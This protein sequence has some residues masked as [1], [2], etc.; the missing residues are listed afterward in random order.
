MHHARAIL[1]T[2][3]LWAVHADREDRQE[4]VGPDVEAAIGDASCDRCGAWSRRDSSTGN[5]TGGRKFARYVFVNS[6]R[7]VAERLA[8]TVL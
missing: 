6:E 3:R 4:H 7:V 1:I 2:D 5:V 8:V